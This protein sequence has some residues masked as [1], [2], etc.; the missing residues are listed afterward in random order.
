[1][2][3][4]TDNLDKLIDRVDA[5]RGLD[6]RLDAD[7]VSELGLQNTSPYWLH[8]TTGFSPMRLT[9]SLNAVADLFQTISPQYTLDIRVTSKKTLVTASW[10]PKGKAIITMTCSHESE[11]RARLLVVLN[12]ERIKRQM[13][14][15]A[16]LTDAENA[17]DYL[18][19][20]SNRSIFDGSVHEVS[21]PLVSYASKKLDGIKI[22]NLIEPK[23][24]DFYVEKDHGRIVKDAAA[25]EIIRNYHP[26]AKEIGDRVLLNLWDNFT[27]SNDVDIITSAARNR[28]NFIYYVLG[29]I[30]SVGVSSTRTFNIDSEETT[31]GVILAN[32]LAK[33]Y[34]FD[35]A[36]SYS[37]GYLHGHYEV[38][39]EKLEKEFLNA[40]V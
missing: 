30:A 1:M 27:R 2:S 24:E 33:G 17:S 37:R 18:H 11:V 19:Y 7:I 20:Q 13:G 39:A 32:V 34:D 36:I 6:I 8:S 26:F 16:K 35:F 29:G 4:N 31:A 12:A 14:G 15:D 22:E 28:S 23:S 9:A 25:A 10:K 5:G 40:D 38:L 3:A 21:V